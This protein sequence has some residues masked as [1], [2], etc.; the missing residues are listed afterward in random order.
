MI[1]HDIVRL[2]IAMHDSPR[3]T[4]IERLEQFVDVVPD[5]VVGQ[6]RVEDFEVGVV[7][8]LEDQGGGLALP[9]AKGGCQPAYTSPTMPFRAAHASTGDSRARSGGEVVRP[10][11]LRV[12]HDIIQVDNV[13][14]TGEVLQDLDLA[15]DLLLL[16][17]L[18]DLDHALVVVDDVDAFEDFR[19][20]H[21]G[22]GV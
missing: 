2:D 10:T 20:L 7:D 4:E 6:A 18:E 15:L 21:A 13:L 1:N 12:P 19:V 22:R 9:G 16:D 14:P 5:V 8:V 11:H 3:V 17:G